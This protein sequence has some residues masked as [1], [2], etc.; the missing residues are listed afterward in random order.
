VSIGILAIQRV[1]NKTKRS[2]FL[3]SILKNKLSSKVSRDIEIKKT[4]MITTIEEVLGIHKKKIN[5]VNGQRS[6][7]DKVSVYPI[8]RGRRDYICSFFKRQLK[9]FQGKNLNA[10]KIQ[11][12]RKLVKDNRHCTNC[13]FPGHL[14]LKCLRKK[15]CQKDQKRHN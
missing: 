10:F 3:L 9:L 12:R 1:F 14:A 2:P 7:S 5:I 11:D 13:F 4:E 6:A 15:S 8:H